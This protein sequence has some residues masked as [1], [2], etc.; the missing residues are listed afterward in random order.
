MEILAC[1]CLASKIAMNSGTT[2]VAK[3]NVVLLIA[4]T[5][6]GQVVTRNDAQKIPTFRLGFFYK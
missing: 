2:V 5:T 3:R 4:S 6:G 1:H